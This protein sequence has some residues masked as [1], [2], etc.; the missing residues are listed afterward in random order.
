MLLSSLTLN[1][2][3]ISASDLYKDVNF[4]AYQCEISGELGYNK[5]TANG[6]S[7]ISRI[8]QVFARDED[9]AKMISLNRLEFGVIEEDGTYVVKYNVVGTIFGI[10][11]LTNLGCKVI[12]T[13]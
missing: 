10:G 13:K 8:I 11:R 12:P 4:R 3:P 1:A 7:T 6:N 9:E 5:K 2:R